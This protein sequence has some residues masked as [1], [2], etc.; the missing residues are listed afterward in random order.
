MV[1]MSFFAASFFS[2]SSVVSSF[3]TRGGWRRRMFCAGG[4]TGGSQASIGTPAG[5]GS[6]AAGAL[7]W[8]GV[9]VLSGLISGLPANCFHLAWLLLY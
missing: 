8:V 6:P 9:G 5:H 1:A 2:S 3:W 7:L 4:P